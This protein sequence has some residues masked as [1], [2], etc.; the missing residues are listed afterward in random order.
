M[1]ESN[2]LYYQEDLQSMPDVPFNFYAPA[3]VNYLLS[4]RSTGDADGAS[5][6]L[7]MVQWMFKTRPEVVDKRNQV[8]LLETARNIAA[9]QAFYDADPQIYGSFADELSAIERFVPQSH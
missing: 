3:L 5:S 9:R 4:E 1:F 6:F 8:L 2:A 7:N